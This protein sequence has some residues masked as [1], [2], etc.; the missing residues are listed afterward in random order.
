MQLGR[1]QDIAFVAGCGRP[2][3]GRLLCGR[4]G[5]GGLTHR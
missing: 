2:R 4:L 1:Q 5:C 3:C